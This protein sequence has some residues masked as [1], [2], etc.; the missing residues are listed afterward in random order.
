MFFGFV[1]VVTCI[2]GGIM[3][4]NVP[5]ASS[6]LSADLTAVAT[7][8][9]V[10]STEGFPEPGIIVI[11]GERISYSSISATSFQGNV[12]RPLTRGISGTTAVAHTEGEVVRLVESS[13]INSSI[14]YDIATISDSAGIQ[15]FLSVPLALF[16]I[17]LSFGIAPF[18][19]L[20]TDLQILTILW[21]ILFLGM[22]VSFFISM[23]G[24]RRV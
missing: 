8:V 12:A 13:L 19:F 7:T 21:G 6:A 5:F 14:D 24:G 23:A 18:S 1:W 2:A 9:Y 20:G 15:A 11:G 17:I 16:D 22:V 4:G 10:E 3:M